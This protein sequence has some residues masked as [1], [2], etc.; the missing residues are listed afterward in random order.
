MTW[1]EI[2]DDKSLRDLPFEIETNGRG[3]IIMSPHRIDHSRY[4]LAIQR[5]LM[6]LLP[7]GEP[8]P[9]LAVQTDDGVRVVDVGWVTREHSDAERG[10]DVCERAPAIC[11]EVI[12]PANSDEEMAHKRALY[13]AKGA[14]E[15]WI[16]SE[17]GEVR[18]FDASGE[19]SASQLC[20][21]F[22]ARVNL[23]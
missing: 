9:E 2:C 16:C 11:V 21:G 20:P 23:K 19:L 3:Q 1:T 5:R 14:G 22:P 10:H 15:V 8:I 6:E 18:F 7:H 13:F 4:Q 17:A 12:S